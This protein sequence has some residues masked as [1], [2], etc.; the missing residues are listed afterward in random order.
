MERLRKRLRLWCGLICVSW[1]VSVNAYW[2]GVV[3]SQITLPLNSS[4]SFDIVM[5]GL[6]A[7]GQVLSVYDLTIGYN[8]AILQ[9]AAA[10]SGGGLG[11]GS[12][13][14]SGP[15]GGL[16]SLFELSTLPDADLAAL[17]GN[18]L[19]L[20]TLSFT[21]IGLGTSPLAFDDLLALG[22]AQFLNAG[23]QFET[24]DLLTLPYTVGSASATV[25]P[26]AVP[27]PGTLL[28]LALALPL[29]A[30]AVKRRRR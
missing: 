11:S 9:F 19:T 1:C 24:F 6:E 22:G 12:M 14:L 21:G 13:F 26:N 18:S 5:T 15:A 28:L 8:P 3:P 20:A 23:G 4:F 2:I 10:Q 27:E 16:V 17:Q 29:L 25:A 7:D 30:F